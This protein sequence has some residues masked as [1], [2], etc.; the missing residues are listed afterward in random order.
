MAFFN[1]LRGK[2]TE[3]KSRTGIDP[4]VVLSEDL[5]EKY[6]T[7]RQPHAGTFWENNQFR[8]GIQLTEKQ[9]KEYK[10]RR[11]S[12]VPWNILKSTLEQK[13]AL[14]TANNPSYQV[15]AKEDSDVNT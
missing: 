13:K 9:E 2:K 7:A 4:E 12:P 8:N 14:L 10:I 15:T 1:A 11:Q 5:L 3:D 6:D